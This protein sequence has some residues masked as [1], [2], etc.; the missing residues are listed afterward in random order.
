M[1]SRGKKKKKIRAVFSCRLQLP[2][3]ALKREF[4]CYFSVWL[5]LNAEVIS[6]PFEKTIASCRHPLLKIMKRMG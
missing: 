3:D 1:K 5:V 4:P 6:N 2:K